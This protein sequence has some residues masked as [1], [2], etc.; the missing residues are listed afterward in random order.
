MESEGTVNIDAGTWYNEQVTVRRSLTL[1]ATG[2]AVVLDSLQTMNSPT[3]GLAGDLEAVASSSGGLDLNR[4]SLVGDATLR[5]ALG[6]VTASGGADLHGFSLDA[7]GAS[8][9]FGAITN[10]NGVSLS[11]NNS[12]LFVPAISATGGGLVVE[13]PG[14]SHSLRMSLGFEVDAGSLGAEWDSAAE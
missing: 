13:L 1:L 10:G 11:A 4:I 12:S 9:S 14:R 3:I 6:A 5:G 2:G 7:A 8:V